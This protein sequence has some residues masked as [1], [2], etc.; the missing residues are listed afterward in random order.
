MADSTF[1]WTSFS[2]GEWSPEAQG[3]IDRPEYKT[4]MNVCLNGLPKESHVWTRRPGTQFGAFTRG[5]NPGRLFS[6]NF[7]QTTPYN[8]EFTDGYLRFFSGTTLVATNDSQ[9]CTIST[10]NPAVV[11]TPLAHSWATGNHVYFADADN[12]LID[13]RQ[14]AIT[15]TDSTH[16]T[17]VDALT[18]AAINGATL[19]TV[20]ASVTVHRVLE[21]TTLYSNSKWETLRSV[22]ADQSAIF[23]HSTVPAQ[24]LSVVTRPSEGLSGTFTLS[25]AD[26][27]DGPYYD[28][29][30]GGATVTPNQLNGNVTLTIGFPAYDSTKSYSIGNY[31]SS[32]NVNYKSLTTGNQGNTPATSPSNWVAVSAGIAVGPNGFQGS[33]IGRHIRLLSEPPL[34]TV[35]TAY[36]VGQYITFIDTTGA[37]AYYYC[38]VNNTA[39]VSNAPGSGSGYWGALAFGARWT[40]GKITGLSNLINPALS[41]SANLGTATNISYAFDGTTNQARA[42][43]S[44]AQT[45]NSY[46]VTYYAGKNYSGASAQAISSVTVFPSSDV[47]FSLS[48]STGGGGITVS[49][50][51]INLRA[52]AT[53]PSSSSDGTLLGTYNAGATN[54]YTP[55]TIASTDSTTTWNYVWVEIVVNYG[56]SAT[57]WTTTIYVA[58]IQFFNPTG[59]GSGTGVTVQI[60]GDPLLYTTPIRTWRLGLYSDTTG[61][62]TCGTYHEGRLW[63]SGSVGNRIDGSKSNEIYNFSPTDRMGVVADSNAISYTFNAPDINTIFWMTPDQQGI[64]CGT[65]AGEWLIQASAQ[66]NILTPTSIQAHRVTKIGCANIEPRRTEHTLVFVQRYKRS[67]MEYFADVYSGKFTAP[68]LSKDAKHLAIGGI[69]QIAYQQELVPIIWALTTAGEL[70]GAT[71]R[72]AT[73]MTSQGPTSIGWHRHTLGENHVVKSICVGPSVDGALDALTILAQDPTTGHHHVETLTNIPNEETTIYNG[74]FLDSAIVPTFRQNATVN[75]VACLQIGGLWPHEG[76]QVTVFAGG[77]DLGEHLVTNGVANIPY[78]TSNALFT[79]NY[80]SAYTGT[81]PIIAGDNYTSDGQIVRPTIVQEIGARNPEAL[82]TKGRIHSYAALLVNTQGIYFGTQFNKLNKANFTTEP[83]GGARFA[84]TQI[85]NGLHRS[86]LTDG[87]S[88]DGMICWRVSRPF[89]ATI[90]ALTGFTKE[91]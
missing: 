59:S 44:Y 71:Y 25:A 36:T 60:I 61:Y 24:V 34:W 41:G 48:P 80:V 29:I 70:I 76:E 85:K 42:A 16:F 35:G 9:T 79:A 26:F 5:G 11:Q 43:C 40:W 81:M 72:R 21:F 88:F 13:N 57:D 1:T 69:E 17:L 20:G 66:N 8:M 53:A 12:G 78:G 87:P 86:P 28:P 15:V 10:A 74:W 64:I 73:L 82:G 49:N 7:Q 37:S 90:A 67:I 47:G 31:V 65:Q 32:S 91:E 89:P 39:A 83:D 50:L 54:V 77:L 27:I 4:A 84:A 23:L 46:A 62:P 52:K 30:T 68:N 55:I 38:G 2:G 6:F 22:Q 75:G 3:G 18:G 19:G 14:F 56:G 45:I 51:T 33:D 58:E 63:L